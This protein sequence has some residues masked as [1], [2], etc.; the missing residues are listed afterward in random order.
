MQ[1]FVSVTTLHIKQSTYDNVDS[2]LF[3]TCILYCFIYCKISGST[4]K[5]RYDSTCKLPHVTVESLFAF[6]LPCTQ[7]SCTGVTFMCGCEDEDF[8]AALSVLMASFSHFILLT[9]SFIISF[10]K[11]PAYSLFYSLSTGTCLNSSI[12][13]IQNFHLSR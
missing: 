6:I 12:K 10:F 1:N 3:K 9:L 8:R 7:T 5:S 13:E 4:H 2:A 11:N